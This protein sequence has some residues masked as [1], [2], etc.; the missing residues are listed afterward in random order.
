MIFTETPLQGAFLIDLEPHQDSRGFFARS[1]CRREFEAHGLDPEIAQRNFSFNQKAGTL[2]GMHFQQAPASEAKLVRCLRGRILDVIVDLRPESQTY[3]QH[4]AVELN[5]ENLRALFIPQ[6][7]A[8]GFQ[9]LVDQT[10]VEYQM[11]EYYAPELGSG[12][13]YDEKVFAIAWPMPVTA[14]SEQ[15]LA[16]PAFSS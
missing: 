16:W 7:F 11:S 14:I 12:F 5:D 1:F 3:R 2:R 15:D 13:R 6:F 9:C 10:L 8:H 4:L